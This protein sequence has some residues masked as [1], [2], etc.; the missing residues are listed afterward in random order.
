MNSDILMDKD[1]TKVEAA[2]IL[3]K[4]IMLRPSRKRSRQQKVLLAGVA[5]SAPLIT[6]ILCY[7]EFI[8]PNKST[9]DAFF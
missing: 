9:N 4:D 3:E 6:V 7:R 5:R 1:N 8:A 2:G